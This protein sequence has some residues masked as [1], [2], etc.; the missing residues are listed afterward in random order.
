MGRDE[1]VI[2]LSP[3]EN[4][5]VLT[6]ARLN[7]NARRSCRLVNI[8]GDRRLPGLS[9]MN[10]VIRCAS[11]FISASDWWLIYSLL[12]SYPQVM[13][14]RCSYPQVMGDWS[15]LTRCCFW[16]LTV[17]ELWSCKGLSGYVHCMLQTNSKN[18]LKWSGSSC[19]SNIIVADFSGIETQKII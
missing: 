17:T 4:R 1:F 13:G 15:N 8:S 6:N 19:D 3:R 12:I 18:I 14:D 2:C 9:V 5:P 11:M 7:K 16:P 10:A